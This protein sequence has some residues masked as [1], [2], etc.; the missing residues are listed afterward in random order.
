VKKSEV[1]RTILGER[2]QAVPRLAIASAFAPANIA[3]CKY[4]GKRDQE[5]NLPL[6]SS[7]SISL[8][9]R[10]ATTELKVNGK[11][12]DEIFLNGDEILPQSVF[13]QRLLE[14]LDLFREQAEPKLTITVQSNIP[15]AAGL[16]SSAAGFSA[17]VLALNDLYDWQLGQNELSVLARLG[18][19]SASRSLWQGFVQWHAGIRTDG[20]DSHG[21]HIPKLWPELCVGLLIFSKQ[22]KSLPSRVAMQRTV[23]S[24]PLYQ[25]WP[26]KVSRDL[27]ALK[28]AIS[29]KDFQ[30]LGKSA[31]SNAM[32]M[33]ATMLSAWPPILY[34][35]PE[36]VLA[37]Q[38]IWQLRN[39]GI[40]V[41]FTQDAGPNLKLLFLHRELEVIKTYF[42][43][44]EVLQ[45]FVEYAG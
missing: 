23:T 41:Y 1:V 43:D 31:E 22:E 3:L 26:S 21:E 37:M 28:Q 27:A 45:P 7:L 11:A 10:G 4:W 12:S 2:W 33:H 36:T 40:S 30:L 5:L 16:A 29:V 35:I 17:L 13:S 15:I 9:D 8:G 18:S 32:T 14:F 38:K 24:S 39:E 34:A 42:P 6:T 25:A 19:G 20:M 44:V